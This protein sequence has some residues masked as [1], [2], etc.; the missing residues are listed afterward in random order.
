MKNLFLM[1]C[2][3]LSLSLNAHAAETKTKKVCNTVIDV[4]TKNPKQVC[5]TIKVHKKLEPTDA[6]KKK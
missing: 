2:I 4:K 6:K 5:K 1:L 3:A